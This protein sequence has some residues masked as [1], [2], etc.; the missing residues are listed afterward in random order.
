MWGSIL[1]VRQISGITK[2][3]V[4][5]TKLTEII[6]ESDRSVRGFCF[7]Y[8]DMVVV[9]DYQTTNKIQLMGLEV[10]DGNFDNIID[11]NDIEI[12]RNYSDNGFLKKEPL[13]ITSF[14]AVNSIVEFTANIPDDTVGFWVKCFQN[15]RNYSFSTLSDAS[16]YIAAAQ[17]IRI[18]NTDVKENIRASDF[19]KIGKGLVRRSSGSFV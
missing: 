4:D 16:S 19:E 17:C 7:Y 13:T 15:A 1:K 3:Q 8:L 2:E 18:V 14:D 12:F 11:K 6:C 10:G 5:D 9:V